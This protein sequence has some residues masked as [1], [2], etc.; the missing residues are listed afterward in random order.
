MYGTRTTRYID[1]KFDFGDLLIDR[2]VFEAGTFGNVVTL[3]KDKTE[4]EKHGFR[5]KPCDE[6]FPGGITV[7]RYKI[8][9]DD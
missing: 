5:S 7:W 3:Y 8:T 2:V 6:T 9:K 1:M 4:P